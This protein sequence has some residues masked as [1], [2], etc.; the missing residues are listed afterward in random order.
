[1]LEERGMICRPRVLP[2][3]LADERAATRLDR[4]RASK[5]TCATIVAMAEGNTP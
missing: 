4:I 1:M 2:M 3:V 5:D